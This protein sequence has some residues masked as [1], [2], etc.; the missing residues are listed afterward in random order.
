MK[1]E[2][3]NAHCNMYVKIALVI[4][5]ITSAYITSL[6][7]QNVLRYSVAYN[8]VS[9]AQHFISNQGNQGSS[10]GPYLRSHMTL[11][12]KESMDGDDKELEMN[13][14]QMC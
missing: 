2:A 11:L 1:T 13:S 9:Q 14:P 4:M 7:C 5:S 8:T 6:I 10:E 3:A 12:V